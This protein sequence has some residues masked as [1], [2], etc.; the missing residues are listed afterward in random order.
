MSTVLGI[1][2]VQWLICLRAMKRR[3]TDELVQ[4]VKVE[5]IKAI[6][7]EVGL[8]TLEIERSKDRNK[9]RRWFIRLGKCSDTLAY[10]TIKHQWD[11]ARDAG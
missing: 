1:A 2:E 7:T 5:T 6:A 10:F 4:M 9:Q 3:C 8:S 11:W